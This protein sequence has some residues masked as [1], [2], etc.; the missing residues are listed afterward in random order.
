LNTLRFLRAIGVSCSLAVAAGLFVFASFFEIGF[1]GSP[2]APYFPGDPPFL[3]I[4]ISPAVVSLCLSSI[5]WLALRFV[6]PLAFARQARA[7]TRA[8]LI[9]T[10]VSVLVAVGG[11]AFRFTGPWD[12]IRAAVPR[13]GDEIL[14]ASGGS[15]SHVLTPEEFTSLKQRFMPK[16]V[17]VQ[18]PGFGVVHLRM[19]HGI[20]PYVG[21]DFGNGMNA[22]FDPSTMYCTYSD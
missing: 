12:S 17:A 18:L 5:C 8:F 20:Y 4:A 2:G 11:V 7:I 22:L 1:L 16:P 21:V 13:Y 6:P 9:A 15:K 10:S 3:D 19:A 14:A